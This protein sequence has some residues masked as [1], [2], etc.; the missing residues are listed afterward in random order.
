MTL[1]NIKGLRLIYFVIFPAVSFL[2]SS[3]VNDTEI[4]Q[5][6]KVDS[7]S[8]IMLKAEKKLR[9]VNKDSVSKKF[10]LYNEYSGKIKEDLYEFKNKENWPYICAYSNVRKPF[11]NMVNNYKDFQTGLD[12]SKVHLDNLKH[13]IRKGLLSNDEFD[14]YYKMEKIKAL[15][16]LDIITQRVESA[17]KE[18][19]NFDTVHPRIVRFISDFQNMK[20]KTKSGIK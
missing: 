1:M 17:K 5:L 2:F 20:K 16:L 3:C 18:E 9:E 6:N 14:R 15:A 13:D 8:Q 10:E 11:R 12:S 19:A 7:L 4:K